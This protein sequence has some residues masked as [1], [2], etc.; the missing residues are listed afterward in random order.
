MYSE[1]GTVAMSGL[2]RVVT[3]RREKRD[4]IMSV[5]AW[6]EDTIGG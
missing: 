2:T 5:M 1:Y 4:G 3:E 6:L